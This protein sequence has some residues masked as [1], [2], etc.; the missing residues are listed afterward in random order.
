MSLNVIVKMIFF[1]NFFNLQHISDVDTPKPTKKFSTTIASTPTPQK[2]ET[3]C[4]T[5]SKPPRRRKTPQKPLSSD[6]SSEPEMA[7]D[8]NSASRRPI[9]RATV[10]RV[11]I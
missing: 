5:A 10:S 8:R 6:S 1:L 2:R 9:R 11:C 7:F 4:E 3:T